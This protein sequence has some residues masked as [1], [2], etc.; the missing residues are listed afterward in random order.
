[1]PLEE[2]QAALE[3]GCYCCVMNRVWR[4][5]V[6][7]CFVFFALL[8]IGNS[9]LVLFSFFSFSFSFNWFINFL[10]SFSC[11]VTLL[12]FV[13][14]GLFWFRVCLCMCIFLCFCFYFSDFSFTT[15]LGSFL[16][17]VVVVC[18]FYGVGGGSVFCFNPFIAIKNSLWDL[19][20]LTRS[21][22]RASGVRVLS[23][24]C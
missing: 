3:A 7:I 23:P 15:C 24:G 11:Q 9:T 17:F 6:F 22:T 1:M 4:F 20:S 18:F 10:V 5:W 8:L 2:S 12:D 13:S 14:F 19:G 16:I 21:R